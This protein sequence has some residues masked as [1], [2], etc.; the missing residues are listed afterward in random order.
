MKSVLMKCIAFA[1]SVLLGVCAGQGEQQLPQE[2]HSDTPTILIAQDIKQWYTDDGEERIFEAAAGK[3]EVAGE[4]FDALEKS[5]AAQ[6][7]GLD[8]R[9]YEELEWSKEMYDS[10]KQEEKRY[11][12]YFNLGE[13]VTVRRLDN[14]VVSF[15]VNGYG[16]GHDTAYYIYGRTFDIASGRELQLEDILRSPEEFYAKAVSYIPAQLEKSYGEGL[17]PD[18]EE[19]VRT[20]TFGETP[21]TWYLDNKGIVIQY[22]L[23]S[24]GPYVIGAPFV[25]LPYDAFAAYIK[26]E[27]LNPDSNFIA[28]VEVNEDFSELIGET[29]KVMIISEYSREYSNDKVTVVS[30]DAS[31]TVG[32]FASSMDAYMYVVKRQDGRSFLIFYCDYALNDF[33]TYVYEVTGGNVR[34]CDKLDGAAWSNTCIGTDRIGLTM[35]LDVLG[36]YRGEMVY[37]LTDD[38]KLVQTE[39]IFAVN[40]P[41]QLK[42]IKDLPVTIG[43][44][45]TT[46]PPGSKIRITGT[47][48]AGKAYFRIDTDTGE[49]EMIQYVEGARFWMDTGTGETGMIQY[50]RDEQ[51]ILIDGV[52]ENEYFEMVPYA[53]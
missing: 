25:T 47:D 5:L 11:F 43:G 20:E 3:V 7:S 35:H 18:F 40:T 37:Q 1:L 12:P 36:T 14:H 42:V 9:D 17:Y 2:S 28:R 50:E 29:G 41:R 19:T 33:A 45:K 34:Q 51:Q 32:T 44:E 4:G 16:Y 8:D 39:E 31:E 46:I 48:N 24:V 53:E 26:E 10:C 15:C 49:T 52:P 6:W 23:Y 30:G 13:S 27:Y 22:E 21:A 38:G